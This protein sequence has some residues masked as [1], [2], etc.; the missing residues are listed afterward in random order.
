MICLASVCKSKEK[1][2]IWSESFKNLFH[3][4]LQILNKG[5]DMILSSVS[6]L[7]F[8]FVFFIV[9]VGGGG[10]GEGDTTKTE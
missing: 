6:L 10:V 5:Q 4:S 9:G 3:K 2:N 8:V 1:F 7:C